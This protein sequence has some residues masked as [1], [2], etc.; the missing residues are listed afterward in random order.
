MCMQVG[1]LPVALTMSGCLALQ[2]KHAWP[3]S[4]LT[5]VALILITLDLKQCAPSMN[6]TLT[7]APLD[8][9]SA[10]CKRIC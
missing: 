1:T 5:I 2:T 3:C 9:L 7:G 4:K 8:W 6:R 10:V